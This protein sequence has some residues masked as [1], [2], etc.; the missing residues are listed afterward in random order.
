MSGEQTHLSVIIPAYNEELRLPAT[1]RSVADYLSKQAYGS[2]IL[3]VNDGSDDRTEHVARDFPGGAIPVTVLNHPDRANHGK[4]AAVQA[5]MLQ[6]KG[7]YRLFMDAD[8]ST[9]IEQVERFWPSLSLGIDVVVGSRNI[10]GSVVKVHQ[11]WFKEMAGRLGNLVIQYLAVPGIWDTQAGFKIF[12]ARSA[13]DVFSRLTIHRWGYDIEVLAIAR[14]R[15]YK[16]VEVPIA[17]I[18][19]P[20]SKVGL[21]SYFQ[22]LA[23]VWRV[24]R[25][26]KSGL[27]GVRP[28]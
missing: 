13:N 6:A 8:N 24:R 12:T 26:L 21:G 17:W 27:Y 4:G 22:V 15:G 11:V 18:N 19:A 10:P 16:I 3:V 28:R 9:G 1:L 23:E 20:G 14:T 2:E 25:N 7:R 5:G